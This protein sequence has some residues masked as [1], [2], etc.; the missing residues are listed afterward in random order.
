MGNMHV[1]LNFTKKEN[2]NGK[3]QNLKKDYKK[4]R[5]LNQ[6][7]KKGLTMKTSNLIKFHRW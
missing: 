5:A 1:S 6:Y 2:Q 3:T 7:I 4:W